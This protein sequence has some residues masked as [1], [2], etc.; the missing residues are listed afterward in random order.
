MHSAPFD[1]W[2]DR[3]CFLSLMH[4]FVDW[5]ADKVFC[6]M[7][8]D[9]FC[10]QMYMWESR[11]VY[12]C[13]CRIV[14]CQARAIRRQAGSRLAGSA[15]GLLNVGSGPQG[16]ST[17]ASLITAQMPLFIF[18]IVQLILVP[19]SEPLGKSDLLLPL[20]AVH[21]LSLA[22]SARQAFKT[23]F[24]ANIVFILRAWRDQLE[25]LCFLSTVDLCV[26]NSCMKS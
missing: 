26:L 12:M 6:V 25:F 2:Q 5:C 22:S 21:V 11:R 13:V 10:L 19:V 9:D 8:G 3:L 15:M 17:Q 23:D 7:K 16:G 4:V 20:R 14:V 1:K 18:R 24:R